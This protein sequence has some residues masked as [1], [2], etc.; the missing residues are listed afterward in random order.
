MDLDA[1]MYD[2][3]PPPSSAMSLRDNALHLVG[4]D[5]MSTSDVHTYLSIY[6]TDSK[7]RIEW[8]DDT[9]L[10][11][12][13]YST[14]DAK[15]ALAHLAT[16]PTDQIGSTEKYP[17][18]ANPA[19]PEARLEIRYATDADKKVKGAKDRSRWYL[20]H[21]EDDP[22]SKPRHRKR[23]SNEPYSKNRR[24]ERRVRTGPAAAVDLFADRVS[25]LSQDGGERPIL[26]SD[27]FEDKTTAGKSGED[28]FATRVLEATQSSQRFSSS[29]SKPPLPPTDL[30][31]TR[32]GAS[33]TSL[34]LADRI[35]LAPATNKLA[36]KDLFPRRSSN[37]GANLAS[38]ISGG[39]IRSNGVPARGRARA[40]DLY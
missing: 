29:K 2:S 12:V 1:D 31:A 17:A 10:N 4:V 7:P 37:D 5:D 19:K 14:D 30:F 8:I 33:S 34:S 36:G 9:S 21:P 26:R 6:H 20:F 40:S 22:D 35:S 28:I 27:L 11:L 13:Y 3:S 39:P 18:Q 25:K 24:P 16:A 38:R 32:T 23:V 15:V